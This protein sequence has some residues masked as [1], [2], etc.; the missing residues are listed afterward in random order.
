MLRQ[1]LLLLL[2]VMLLGWGETTTA[3]NPVYGEAEAGR[4]LAQSRGVAEQAARNGVA[5]AGE[6]RQ[7]A[8][9]LNA[10]AS[11][12]A[13][14]ERGLARVSAQRMRQLQLAAEQLEAIPVAVTSDSRAPSALTTISPVPSRPELC[15]VENLKSKPYTR[16]GTVGKVCW[17]PPAE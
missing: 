1:G 17:M 10:I 12:E 5:D 6:Q 14:A 7:I 3:S 8:A 15:D 4:V 9:Q 11:I 2:S 16:P 13:L